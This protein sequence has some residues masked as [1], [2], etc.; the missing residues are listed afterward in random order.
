MFQKT[1]HQGAATLLKVCLVVGLTV[2]T[3]ASQVTWQTTHTTNNTK[4]TGSTTLDAA[5]LRIKV[6]PAYLDVEEDVEIRTSGTVSA[7]NDANTLEILATFTLP[8]GSA[9]TGALLW[10]GSRI[11]Q[12]KLLDR[13]KA[14][15]IYEDLVDRDSVAPPRPIDPLILER[16][17]TN[18]YRLKVY[19]VV[20]GSSRH[21]RLRY[22]LPPKIGTEGFEI[23]IQSAIA[24]LFAPG[25]NTITTTIENGGGVPKIVFAE[26]A[27]KREMTLPRT[28]FLTRTVL[29]ASTAASSTNSTRILPLDTLR[30]V[31]VKTSFDSGGF[32]GNY[33]N[34]YASIGE[35]LLR[36]LGQRVEVVIYWK[37]NNV[38][39]WSGQY[40]YV[41][42][43]QGQAADLLNLYNQLGG[44][45]NR[46]GLLHDNSYNPQR[47]FP[48]A[49]KSEAGYR[50]AVDYLNSVQGNYTSNFINNLQYSGGAASNP[51]TASK[52]QFKQ[53]MQLVKTLY[54]PD[55]GVT[56]HL[57]VVSVGPEYT[58]PTIDMNT[59]FDSIFQS[60]PVSLSQI[61]YSTFNQA[62]FD[63][64]AA[65]QSR[66]ITGTTV[67][68]V[69]ADVPGY[70]SM[71][72]VATVRN[73]AK[74]YDFSVPCTGGVSIACGTLEFHGKASTPWKDTLEWEAYHS[75]GALVGVAKSV[76][77]ILSKIRDTG[78]VV[79]WAGSN[80]PFSETKES[81]LG[82]T[83][84]FVDQW[85]SLLAMERDSISAS[86]QTAYADTGVPRAGPIPNYP[87]PSGI[88]P[89][90]S[91]TNIAWRLERTANGVILLRIPGLASGVRI[92][93]A[94]Y[95]LSGKRVGSWFVTAESGML[96][97]NA[98]SVRSGTYLLRIKGPNIS[99]S[100]LI[101]L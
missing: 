93:L 94:L 100:K 79:L 8:A 4:N 61:K 45:G 57:I 65:K 60:K 50:Q 74:A 97:W 70:P 39:Q 56:R 26:G 53:N 87:G 98:P 14:D 22:Q 48:V 13:F 44:P 81:Q 76:P 99:G 34:L 15:S 90:S 27:L 19:P 91:V 9:I 17:G 32:S 6:F 29:T 24:S 54:S 3:A 36:N 33:L 68:L 78:T 49:S 5:S 31:Q 77:T 80:S 85:A 11:L 7:S 1:N 10:D 101:L 47:Q 55:Q 64:F 72:L 46:V 86:A 66:P 2:A 38:G 59:V 75:G 63:L 82:P 16:T 83:Y 12:A 95:D 71:S 37:W 96:R 25:T 67:E 88:T 21:F 73:A 89:A 42:V 92:E 69:Q 23:R 30:Q 28:V 41:W 20:L 84:G 51:V 40:E 62:G 18:T 58:S 43:A 52:S 35:D